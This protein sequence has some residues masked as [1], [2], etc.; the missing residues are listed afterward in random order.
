[1]TTPTSQPAAIAVLG[2]TAS[3]KT[4]IAEAL[5][6]R[7]QCRIVNADVFQMYRGLDIGTAKPVH[8]EPYDLLDILEPTEVLTAGRFVR[9]AAQRCA[10][11]YEHGCH[12]IVCGG[13][14]L[15]VRAL[16]EDFSRLSPPPSLQE[17]RRLQER[18]QQVG[19][20]RFAQE[21]GVDLESLSESDRRNPVRVLRAAERLAVARSRE[22]ASQQDSPT[23]PRWHAQRLKFS[24]LPTR[25]WLFP[26]IRGRIEEMLALGWEDEVRRLMDDGVPEDAPAFRAIGYREIAALLSGNISREEAVAQIAT[27][28]WQYAKRQLTWLRKEPN[29]IVLPTSADAS[30]HVETICGYIS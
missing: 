6:V 12:V 17:R 21:T 26:R 13:T 10:E 27:Q 4:A 28:T 19:I 14:G 23:L 7:L 24:L 18:L 29:L 20:V 25:E 30:A 2:T 8:R 22:T 5:A 16:F 15:Y 3:G 11:A 1:M 9:L